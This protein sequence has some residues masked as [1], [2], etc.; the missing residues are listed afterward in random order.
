MGKEESLATVEVQVQSSSIAAVC[1]LHHAVLRRV[2]VQTHPP[3]TCPAFS[4]KPT[5]CLTR[6][7]VFFV[8]L[9]TDV[10]DVFT[11]DGC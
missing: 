9:K 3:H 6:T 10:M 1:G 7:D 11:E 5:F 4:E 2:K 8:I